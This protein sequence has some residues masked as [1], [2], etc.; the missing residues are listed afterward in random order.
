MALIECV[1]NLSEGR[2]TEVIDR[3]VDAVRRVDEVRV[4]DVSS[5]S[6]HNRS[7]ITMVGSAP[8]LHTAVLALYEQ[9]IA[10]IDLRSHSGAHPRLGAVDVVPFIPIDGMAMSTCVTLAKETAAAIASR[11]H[12]PVYLYEEAAT[13]PARR[14]LADIRRGE[15]EGL[16]ARL[17]TQEWA[18]DFGPAVPHASAGATVIGARMPLIAFNVNL[19]TPRLDIAKAVA[20]SVR[21]SSGGL[22]Y[23]K[24]LGVPLEDRGIAQV[25][26]NLTNFHETS[27]RR[28]FE[29]VRAEAARHGVAVLESEI[30]GLVPRAALDGTSSEDLQLAGFTDG[31]ILEIRLADLRRVDR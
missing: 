6:S 12:L 27:I 28:A 26:M 2:R 13:T 17:A 25:S 1:P 10:T 29:A 5:D 14:N 4:L 8:S 24:A 18:P 3:L 21:E 23:V 11:F 22:P 16:A 19:A 9:A 7:V 20:R 31:Q 30:V 15:F